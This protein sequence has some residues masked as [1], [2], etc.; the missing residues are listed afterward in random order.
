MAKRYATR[1]VPT[2][3]GWRTVDLNRTHRDYGHVGFLASVPVPV[4]HSFGARAEARVQT[5]EFNA[6][7][8]RTG[9]VPVRAQ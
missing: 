8:E 1:R 9:L 7:F 6:Y 3:R 2:Y 5:D 4:G